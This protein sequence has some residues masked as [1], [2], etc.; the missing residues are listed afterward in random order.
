MLMGIITA[1]QC[2]NHLAL[3]W[4]APAVARFGCEEFV[5]TGS[6]ARTFWTRIAVIA[7][8]FSLV[9]AA[10]P[11]WLPMVSSWLHLPDW[12]IPWMFA[13]LAVSALW[14]HVQQSLQA[15]KLPR[16]QGLLMTLE[17]A[18]IVLLLLITAGQT[19]RI[20]LHVLIAAYVFSPLLT[21]IVGIWFLGD[22]LRTRPQIDAHLL[23]KI[24]RYSLPLLSFSLLV[25]FNSQYLDAF[26]ISHY[27]GPAAL[28][29][30]FVAYQLAGAVLQLPTL[31]GTLV[32]PFMVTHRVDGRDAILE[33]FFTD[34]LPVLSLLW[35]LGCSFVAAIGGPLLAYC[36]GDAFQRTST[37][38]WP[39][40][41]T[42]AIAGPFLIAYGPA[43]NAWSMTYMNTITAAAAGVVNVALN[44]VLIPAFGLIGCA[45]ASVGSCAAGALAWSLLIHRIIPAC[46]RA[47][48]LEAALP[49]IVGAS[50][51]TSGVGNGGALLACVAVFALFILIRQD[52]LPTVKKLFTLASGRW[53]PITS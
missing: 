14:L 50:L 13:H 30:Y 24:L 45:W 28:G 18:Q 51:A 10:S 11:L 5:G 7:V 23:Q 38:L 4:T 6:I 22:T 32:L 17:R 47:R 31:A 33:R 48:V 43:S 39:M 21:A 20:S 42:A 3:H 46:P 35:G 52:V 2:I 9:A 53:K 19:G 16:V 40:M 34:Y 49:T 27:L 26:F 37:L 44:L 8:S 36:F 1:S 41:A 25:Y 15:A 12:A 29:I